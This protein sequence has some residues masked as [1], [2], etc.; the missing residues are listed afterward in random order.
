MNAL[1]EDIEAAMIVNKDIEKALGKIKNR[2]T[3]D[4]VKKY[5]EYS[6]NIDKKNTSIFF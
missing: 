4:T 2:L 6:Q 3:A 1:E 5:E